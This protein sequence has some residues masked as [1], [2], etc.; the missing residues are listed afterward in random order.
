[1]KQVLCNLHTSLQRLVT[2]KFSLNQILHQFPRMSWM[3]QGDFQEYSMLQRFFML[4]CV[5]LLS[6]WPL[7]LMHRGCVYST[8]AWQ[9][10]ILHAIVKQCPD[11]KL[12]SKQIQSE[13]MGFLKKHNICGP[14]EQVF[15]YVT[16][17]AESFLNGY[18][19]QYFHDDT[20]LPMCGLCSRGWRCFH[21]RTT[22]EVLQYVH[23]ATEL[24][25]K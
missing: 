21:G 5:Q 24:L 9:S 1:M 2:P 14:Q 18:P 10:Y 16:Q 11:V 3:C 8:H 20:N 15:K 23:D 4:A 6:C 13:A 12:S 19:R 25:V 7:Q 17:V 22:S